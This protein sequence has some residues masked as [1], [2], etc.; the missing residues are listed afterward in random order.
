MAYHWKSSSASPA[1]VQALGTAAD[2]VIARRFRHTRSQVIYLR[3]LHHIAAYRQPDLSA[4]QRKQ[5]I[6]SLRAGET[7]V[8]TVRSFG[9]SYLT[10]HKI[11]LEHGW[12]R[13]WIDHSRLRRPRQYFA[14]ITR[15]ELLDLYRS[16]M[17]MGL[18]GQRAG[19]TRER[20]RQIAREEGL[21]P[22]GPELRRARERRRDELRTQWLRE[23]RRLHDAREVA[24][25]RR[26]EQLTRFLNRARRLWRQ[27]AT[28]SAI[29]AAYRISS[30][31]MSWHIHIGR[32]R[33][34]WFPRRA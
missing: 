10:V 9:L 34:G 28:I 30:K 8:A 29:A 27:G 31:S 22:R 1:L 26:V 24:R 16:G 19:I 5:V 25:A 18:I 23:A 6:A 7:L 3:D 32:T 13:S 15:A 21:P 12:Q 33:L 11:A 2:S 20:V 17:S 4:G 14:A